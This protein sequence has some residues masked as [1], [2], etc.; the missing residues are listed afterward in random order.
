MSK[1]AVA[2]APKI[3][4]YFVVQPFEMSAKGRYKVGQPVQAQSADQA[5]RRAERLAKEQGGAIAF[6]RK[7]D[8]EFGDFEDAVLLGRFG[9]V[10]D[11]F[12]MAG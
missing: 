10:P 4:T 11:D 5:L 12:L 3:V 7:G 1:A 9:E 2:T 6:S 8:P